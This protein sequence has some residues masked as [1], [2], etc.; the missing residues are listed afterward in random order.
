MVAQAASVGDEL[1]I[2]VLREAADHFA[3]WL[4]NI[5]ELF[6]PEVIVVGGGLAH[7]MMASVGYIRNR[8]VAWAVNRRGSTYPL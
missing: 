7:L 3:I 4:G 1:A 6:E 2:E 5:I 8:L